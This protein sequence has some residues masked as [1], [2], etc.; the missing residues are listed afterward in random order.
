V[1]QAVGVRGVQRPGGLADHRHGAGGVHRPLLGQHRGDVAAGHQAHVEEQPAVD[2]AE[3]VDG[4]DVRLVQPGGQ[5]RLAA[6]AL[7][8]A[9]VGGEVLGED[10]ERD[11]AVV[12]GVERAIDLAH[13]AATQQGLDP[14][15]AELLQIHRSRAP[16][17]AAAEALVAAGARADVGGV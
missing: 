7:A 10:L 11:H 17:C 16:P 8:V 2:L 6:E 12:L 5:V 14:I 4:H 15:G 13:A 3:A 1:H 9:R